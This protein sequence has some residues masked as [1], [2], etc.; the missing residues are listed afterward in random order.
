MAKRLK[1]YL[2]TSVPNA[3]FDK[4]NSLRKEITRSFWRRL[5][6]YEVFISNLV[7]EEINDIGDKEE[8]P[9]GLNKWI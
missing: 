5:D 7:L 9:V 6:E 8:S 4:R 2:D 3:Y 1:I